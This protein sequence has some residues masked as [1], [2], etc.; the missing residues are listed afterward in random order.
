MTGLVRKTSFLELSGATTD[1]HEALGWVQQ[2]RAELVF[3]DLTMPELHG[4][5]FIRMSASKCRFVVITGF[6]E[7][8]LQG[9]EL[10]VLDYV[11]KPVNYERF[12]KAAGKALQALRP[13]NGAQRQPDYS[14]FK[15]LGRQQ[16]QKV[17]HQDI[18]YIQAEDRQSVIHT[19]NGKLVS[20][21]PLSELET[22]LPAPDFIRV[23]RSFIVSLSKI[24]MISGTTIWVQRVHIPVGLPYQEKFFSAI[25]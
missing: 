5:D 12:L 16:M 9:Y 21:S 24:E 14:F 18:L 20:T 13:S 4:L 10:D 11:M 25:S 3:L 22:M 6:E 7:F 17:D 1:P 15:C 2:D 23:H 8:A 19:K